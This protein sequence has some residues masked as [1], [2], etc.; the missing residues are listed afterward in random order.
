MYI[1]N[2]HYIACLHTR[3]HTPASNLILTYLSLGKSPSFCPSDSWIS[4]CLDNI[5]STLYFI[6]KYQG[7]VTLSGLILLSCAT[8]GWVCNFLQPNFT[9]I[10]NFTSISQLYSCYTTQTNQLQHLNTHI[11]LFNAHHHIN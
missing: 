10:G 7:V 4:T 2:N 3:T 6:I 9:C 11:V 8:Q 5:K 1:E